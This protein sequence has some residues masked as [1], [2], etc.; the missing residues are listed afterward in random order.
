MENGC[1]ASAVRDIDPKAKDVDILKIAASESRIVITMDKDFGELFCYSRKA[2]ASVL[3][4]RLADA[5]ADEKIEVLKNILQG[6]SDQIENCLCVYQ[7]GRLR[8]RK[9]LSHNSLPL[10]GY[11]NLTVLIL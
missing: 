5:R 10:F 1:D 2:H 11:W 8:V 4:L 7:D 6:Y 3:I 9:P